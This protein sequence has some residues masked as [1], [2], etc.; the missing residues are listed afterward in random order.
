MA[1]YYDAKVLYDYTALAFDELTLRKGESVEVRVDH[2]ADAEEGW[3]SGADARGNHGVF[4]ANYVEAVKAN[5]P[6]IV[7][8]EGSEAALSAIGRVAREHHSSSS[9]HCP[10][11]PARSSCSSLG[12]EGSP[13]CNDELVQGENP[14]E[15]VCA[16]SSVG[17][18]TTGFDRN[19]Q[20]DRDS[21]DRTN[22]GPE[23]RPI[24]EDGG[25]GVG[26]RPPHK[27]SSPRKEARQ[28]QPSGV[29][30]LGHKDSTVSAFEVSS[31]HC[32]KP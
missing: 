17:E 32:T 14:I 9:V 6:G 15:E 11:G 19:A 20:D 22:K 27:H 30:H 10:A 5:S 25:V 16:S 7:K 12:K 23:E 4:P 24:T 21:W 13:S 3:L 28:L 18:G 29:E 26:H 1:T 8:P 2:A 31:S